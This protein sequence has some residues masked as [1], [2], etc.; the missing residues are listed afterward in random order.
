[1][2]KEYI[3]NYFND[4]KKIEHK[5]KITFSPSSFFEC[6]R[7]L[8]Y[9]HFG[10]AHSNPIDKHSQLKM[11]LGNTTHLM[12]QDILKK[13]G[14]YKSGEEL[15]N[16]TYEGLEFNYKI[17]G[18]L[19]INNNKYLLEIKTIYGAGFNS[20]QKQPKE[21]HIFQIIAYMK[22]EGLNKAVLLYIGRD[23]GHMIEYKIKIENETLYIGQNQFNKYN[24]LEKF[25][26]KVNELKTLH[27]LI[28]IGDIPVKDYKIVMKNT[29][30]EI[31]YDFIHNKEHY[32]S[33]WQCAYCTYKTKCW[34]KEIEQM[35]KY[36]YYINGE[37]IKDD[38]QNS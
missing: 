12:I 28:T 29:N 30:E 33:D 21:E 34:V 5:E 8:F 15:K 26:D 3:Y 17:D 22:F 11:E 23:N 37:F 24:Y 19:E 1:M 32:K 10:E 35:T 36:K 7:K 18:L 16:T 6:K 2:V 20:I 31:S 14:I 27:Y 25:D 13:Q 38:K 4:L 9:K